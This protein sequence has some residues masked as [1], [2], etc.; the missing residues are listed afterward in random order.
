MS[1]KFKIT[2]RSLIKTAAASTAVIAAPMTLRSQPIPVRKSLASSESESDVSTYREAVKYML[3]QVDPNDPANFHLH[4]YRNAMI[5]LL[6]CPHG[7]WWF[8]VWHRPYLGYL[9]QKIRMITGN[10]EFALPFWDW[11]VTQEIPASFMSDPDSSDLDLK[12]N[13]LDPSSS[14]YTNAPA[15]QPLKDTHD[16]A[17]DEIIAADAA[18]RA[19][20]DSGDAADIAQAEADFDT[21]LPLYLNARQ[22]LLDHTFPAFD[23]AFRP[24][25]ETMWNSFTTVQIAQLTTRFGAPPGQENVDF[26]WFWNGPRNSVR[27]NFEWDAGNA[28]LLKRPDARFTNPRLLDVVDPGNINAAVRSKEFALEMAGESP[29]VAFNSIQADNH[30]AHAQ[31]QAILEGQPHNLVHNF[32]GEVMQSN[33]SSI[34]PIFFAHHA[35]VDRVWDVWTRRQQTLTP[36]GPFLPQKDTAKFN[37]EEFLFYI[38]PDGLPVTQDTT[39]GAFMD[40]NRFGYRYAPGTGEDQIDDTVV[41]AEAVTPKAGISAIPKSLAD[42]NIAPFA[43]LSLGGDLSSV[44][45][46]STPAPNVLAEITAQL[47]ANLVG[48]N[49]D[50]FVAPEGDGLE[51]S[52]NNAL[53]AGAI[54]FF[55]MNGLRH[56]ASDGKDAVQEGH[57]SRDE[58]AVFDVDITN[59]IQSLNASGALPTGGKVEISLR[60]E[61]TLGNVSS[62]ATDQ[63]NLKSVRLKTI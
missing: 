58:D 39:A 28:R 19:A 63:V 11:S 55:G 9:E 8:A 7:N 40:I 27:E 21:K 18:L 41:F 36:P 42:R 31:T 34:D 24:A 56:N 60:A 5:H 48:L 35:N 20:Q 6:D 33:L 29:A 14:Y 2:R 30:H 59:A 13:P 54:G 16:T 51:S 10:D 52:G 15:N 22:D 32:T 45:N 37:S 1:R 49:I 50:I 3:T 26:A 43:T 53:L 57:H 25:F 12:D 46:K 62:D 44:F 4:W 23:A 61:R 47:P 38:M 17:L